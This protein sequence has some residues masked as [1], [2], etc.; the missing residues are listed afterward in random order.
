MIMTEKNFE[1]WQVGGTG[2]LLFAE[3]DYSK[4]KKNVTL[5]DQILCQV[6]G[7]GAPAGTTSAQNVTSTGR[8]HNIIGLT[9]HNPF[10]ILSMNDDFT[11]DCR[12]GEYCSSR[13][14]CV[15]QLR[16]SNRL[17]V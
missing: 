9:P 4:K 7:T 2:V 15:R 8:P 16:D 14:Q 13:K 11:R 10:T 17:A 3:L 6:G 12:Y 1:T 5:C